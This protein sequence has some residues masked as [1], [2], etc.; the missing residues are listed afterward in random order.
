MNMK[1]RDI[2]LIF[3]IS[4]LIGITRSVI[5]GDV[6]I[7]K[8][9]PNVVDVV[10]DDLFS[11]INFID[12]ELSKKMY[13]DGAVFID[14]RDASTYSKGHI[15]NSVNVPWEDL[16]NDKIEEILKDIPYDQT[17]VT[18]CSGGDCTLSLD[19]A[20][21]M[22]DELGYEKVLVFEGGYPKWT[23]EKYPTSNTKDDE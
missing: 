9:A 3:F 1:M 8:T 4:F 15:K 13:D 21:F 23:E 19:I 7:I 12:L 18:Y 17:V 2:V 5:L 6:E 10:S 20:S 16:S 11:S 22:F 14:A